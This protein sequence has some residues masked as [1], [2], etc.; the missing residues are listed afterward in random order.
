MTYN[1][2][3]ANLK[4]RDTAKQAVNHSTMS[5]IVFQLEMENFALITLLLYYIL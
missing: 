3:L 2:S 1:S 4:S 5:C